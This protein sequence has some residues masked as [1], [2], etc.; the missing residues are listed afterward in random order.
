MGGS[1]GGGEDYIYNYI[2]ICVYCSRMGQLGDMC[3]G[4]GVTGKLRTLLCELWLRQEGWDKYRLRKEGGGGYD[5]EALC[6]V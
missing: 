1:R 3:G 2:Y 5:S 4:G 6:S